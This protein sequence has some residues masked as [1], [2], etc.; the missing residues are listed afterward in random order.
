MLSIGF[1]LVFRLIDDLHLCNGLLN[2]G[3]RLTHDGLRVGF[4]DFCVF[5]DGFVFGE[6][7]EQL[8]GDEVLG[9]FM[10]KLNPLDNR[11]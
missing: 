7:G 2:H 4:A 3:L 11:I 5:D 9:L 1:H 10:E 6:V 8:L